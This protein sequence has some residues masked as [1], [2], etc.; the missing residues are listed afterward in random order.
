MNIK[1]AL[2]SINSFSELLPIIQQASAKLSCWSGRY[3]EINGYEGALAIDQLAEKVDALFD[4]KAPFDKS[5]NQC[6]REVIPL[7]IQIY[8]ESDKLY[9][10]SGFV[11]KVVLFVRENL[12]AN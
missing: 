10:D 5:E 3:V 11:T 7:I 2:E 12:S 9:E 1:D 6:R 4:P 8:K